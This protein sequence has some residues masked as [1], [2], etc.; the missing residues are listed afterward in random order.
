MIFYFWIRPRA[1]E[2]NVVPVFADFQIKKGYNFLQK[3][4]KNI[5]LVSIDSYELFLRDLKVL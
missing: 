4:H 3:N 1:K 5:K 2:K